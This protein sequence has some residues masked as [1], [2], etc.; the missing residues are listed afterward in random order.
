MRPFAN[1]KLFTV[2]ARRVLQVAETRQ[3]WIGQKWIDGNPGSGVNGFPIAIRLAVVLLLL[4]GHAVAAPQSTQ[5]KTEAPKATARC[6]AQ[7]FGRFLELFSDSPNLQRRFTRLP[8]EYGEVIDPGYP[9]PSREFALRMIESYD[10]IPL[11]DRRDG[12]R[13]FPSRTKRNRDDLVIV[14]ERG[15]REEPEF[16][17]ERIVPDDEVVLLFVGNTGFGIYFR[18]ARSGNCWFLEAIHDK[19]TWS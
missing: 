11:F 6:P 13:I 14:Q 16:P 19:S 7:N 3:E 15:M 17:D 18:F 4:I 5:K 2:I 9:E 10:K 8:L 12:G 1:L